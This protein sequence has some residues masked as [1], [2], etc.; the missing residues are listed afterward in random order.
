MTDRIDRFKQ[1][2][3]DYCERRLQSKRLGETLLD[4]KKIET[5][6]AD[7]LIELMRDLEIKTTYSDGDNT[8]HRITVT[9]VVL[10]SPIDD[11]A[12]A[13]LMKFFINQGLLE[14]LK[15]D[16]RFLASYV[17]ELI[18]DETQLDS[19]TGRY[20]FDRVKKFERKSIRFYEGRQAPATDQ[21]F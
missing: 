16:K 10:F 2:R 8:G 9:D 18:D 1:L 13:E 7:E 15:I 12:N 20:I 11:Q 3:G 5:A 4:R 19:P 14:F 6:I 21:T 17:K